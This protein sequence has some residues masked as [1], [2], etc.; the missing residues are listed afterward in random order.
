MNIELFNKNYW[1]RRFG[2]QQIIRGIV[3]SGKTDFIAS[4]NVH[5]LGVDEQQD[6]PE[7]ERMVKKLEAH[8][9]VELVVAKETANRKGDLL[10]YHGRW[11][12]CV[13]AQQWDHTLLSHTNYQFVIVPEDSAHSVDTKDPPTLDPNG[14]PDGYERYELDMPIATRD[15]V[16]A[17][18]IKAGGGLYIDSEGYL[19]IDAATLDQVR[20]ILGL[21][22]GE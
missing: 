9:S 16:G 7:G 17:V 11:Y 21:F 14:V 10:L 5:P 8:G 6:L 22:G 3:T 19:S 12:E 4:L 13:D 15:K 1:V 2:D 20:E 18:I